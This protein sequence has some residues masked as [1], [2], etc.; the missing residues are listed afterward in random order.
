MRLTRIGA[1]ALRAFDCLG[2]VLDETVTP[3]ANLVAKDL[4]APCPAR[5]DCAF[6]DDPSLR[7][8][9]IA[10]RRLLDHESPF[11]CVHDERRVVEVASR[12]VPQSCR[13]R[14]VDAAVK[15]H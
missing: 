12:P 10:N 5:S 2:D 8:V 6:R 15:P 13:Y 1:Q 7:T 4:K 11:R 14:L 9:G 3:A